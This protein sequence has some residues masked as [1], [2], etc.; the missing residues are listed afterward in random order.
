M[1]LQVPLIN[2]V[3]EATADGQPDEN[4]Q[5]NCVPA[6]IASAVNYLLGKTLNG[7]QIKDAVYGNGYTGATSADRFVPYLQGMGITMLP[8][9]G[10]PEDL[11]PVVRDYIANGVPCLMTI[12]SQWANPPDNQD[13]PSGYTHV[14]LA[15]GIDHSASGTI[16]AMN[17][18]GGFLQE[19]PSA[20]WQFRLCFNQI[21]SLQQ[22][23]KMSSAAPSIGNPVAGMPDWFDDGQKLWG[24]VSPLDGQRHFIRGGFRDHVLAMMHAGAWLANDMPLEEEHPNQDGSRT[25]QTF[26][27]HQ[28]RVDNKSGAIFLGNF[29]VDYM[30]LIGIVNGLNAQL[31][32][33]QS[34]PTGLTVS[35][36]YQMVAQKLNDLAQS[37]A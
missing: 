28:W 12:P 22:E 33:A 5:M 4:A 9:S 36:A 17:P 24:P 1:L 15:C 32:S 16:T 2:Q 27:Y 11:I 8:H 29:G 6:S 18:W 7:D 35:Q 25:I 23:V 14:V 10:Q 13:N 30:R 34:K 37:G 3:H 19:Q 20:W 31:Q 26:S 21:W